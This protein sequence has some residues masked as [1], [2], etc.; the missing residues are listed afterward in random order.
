MSWIKKGGF[1]IFSGHDFGG[2]NV[3]LLD[4]DVQTKQELK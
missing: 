1:V 2:V 4:I 3:W